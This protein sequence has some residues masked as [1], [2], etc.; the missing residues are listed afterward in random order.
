MCG[1]PGGKSFFLVECLWYWLTAGYH[2]A[3]FMLELS[4]AFHAK[5][6]H[7]MLAVEPRLLDMDWVRGNA[8]TAVGL[9]DRHAADLDRFWGILETV[10]RGTAVTSAVVLDWLRRR[11]L[12]C[13]RVLVVD[14]FTALADDQPWV[15]DVNL[16][17]PL[18]RLPR[19]SARPVDRPDIAP[20]PRRQADGPKRRAP[21]VCRYRVLADAIRD[22][23]VRGKCCSGRR[24]PPC[25]NSIDRSR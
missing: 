16:F 24:R 3:C 25:R 5:R 17:S 19:N 23:E 21:A 10:P 15:T 18:S 7:A 2:V 13:A 20:G 9:Y 1:E 4:A 12:A 8:A 6:L 11:C 22:T 14:P